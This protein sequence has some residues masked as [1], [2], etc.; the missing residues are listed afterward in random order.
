MA[1]WKSQATPLSPPPHGKIE[2]F[3]RHCIYS[4][5]S[6]HKLRLPGFR[7]DLCFR[8]L[9]ETMD[10]GRVNLT[11]F[12]D[13]AKGESSSH[14]LSE[15][16]YPIIET[17]A[18]SEAV[19]FLRLLTHIE[20]LDLD[21]ETVIY[22]V[23]DDYLHRSGWIDV[24]LQGIQIPGVDYV[25]LYDHKDKYFWPTYRN[26][27]SRIFATASCH[28]R[29]TPSTTQTFA[30]RWKT[31][32]RDM[33]IHR[34]FSENRIISADHQKFCELG[35][36]GAVLVSP[37]PGWSTHADLEYASPCLDWNRYFITDSSRSK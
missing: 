14:F 30:T 27:T 29:T 10:P 32:K 33:A 20:S 34:K 6:Q 21:P 31:L 26:L 13:T 12:L 1:R 9:I 4:S 18:G 7:R 24:L 15:T 22:I 36:R 23:E 25:T 37:M 19:A 17:Q 28:W 16:Q 2:L 35:R 3:S 5:I 11:C 8:N